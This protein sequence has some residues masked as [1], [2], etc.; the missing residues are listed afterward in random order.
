MLSAHFLVD[1]RLQL[2]C[3]EFFETDM[4]L[5]LTTAI[6]PL[7]RIEN[8]CSV[9]HRTLS[10]ILQMACILTVVLYTVVLQ[11]EPLPGSSVRGRIVDETGAGVAGA[12]ITAGVADRASATTGTSG[13]GDFVL[14]L[15]PGQY[16]LKIAA[17]GFVDVTRDV[18]IEAGAGSPVVIQLQIRPVTES[19]TVTDSAGY[20][21]VAT[22]SATRTPTPIINIPQSLSIIT[23][24]LVKDQMMMSIGDVVRYVP[25][26]M[27]SQGENNRD[28]IVIRGNSS[29][30]D[31]FVNGL[32]D[33]VQYYRDL[34]NVERVEVLKGPNA[35]TFGRGGGGGVINRVTKQAGF[36]DLREIDIQAGSFGTRRVATDWDRAFSSRAAVRLN[37]IYENSD[38]FRDF[39]GVERYGVN[40]T[41]TFNP[42]PETRVSIGYEYFHDRRTADRGI[43]SFDGKP[44]GVPISMFFGN[45]DD[46]RVRAGV[47]LG[48]ATVEH[49]FGRVNLR[50]ATLVGDYDRGYQNYVPRGVNADQTLVSM[51]A[52]N[53]ATRRRN[54]FNQTDLSLTASTGG[55]HHTLLFGGEIGRQNT[56]NFRNT[57]Y[58]NDTSTLIDVPYGNPS[59][60]TPTTF[61]QSATDADNHIWTNV[62][63]TYFQDQIEISRFVQ[64]LAGVRVDRFDLAFHNN[65][66]NSSLGRIDHLVSPRAGLVLKPA[67]QVSVYGS[68]SVSWLP[69]SGDQFSSLTDVTQQVKPEKFTNYEVGVKWD[70]RRFLSITTAVYRLDRTNTRATD[71]NNPSQIVQT[72][73]QRSNGFEAGVN[74]AVTKKWQVSGGYAYQDAFISNPT[75]SAAL[76]AQVAQVPHHTFSLWN[77]YRVLPRLS[78]GLGVLNRSDMFAAIDNTVVLPGYVRADAAVFYSITERIRCQAN[79][80]NIFNKRYYLNA[81]GN[82]NI[83]PGSPRAIQIGLI[84]SF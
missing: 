10:S 72:G 44:A 15:P 62:A 47:H 66:T 8:D 60:S 63:A 56:D 67:A 16:R 49:Q 26:V 38:T 84:A 59:I 40:P 5:L 14:S 4:L 73:S 19:V 61:R 36:A 39:V 35:M 51:S 53:N 77:H 55:V 42:A 20:Q 3:N 70:V 78:A 9:T 11:G 25:G 65:R 52:Y 64:I 32:R 7:P 50:N 74:G 48:S 75:M 45:P 43:P 28:Q 29:S 81:D 37:A 57:G 1:T 33:D 12:R 69:S 6:R 80:Q 18:N 13:N 79:V 76:G 46:S 24:D 2:E 83:S 23:G 27:A 58:F 17:D 21:A 54:F 41:A 68:Y 34:Y 22:S 71:P 82:N 30:A 31:F